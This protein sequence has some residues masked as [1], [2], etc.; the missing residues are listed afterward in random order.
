MANRWLRGKAQVPL[1][2]CP[3]ACTKGLHLLPGPGV[4]SREVKN[5]PATEE[6]VREELHRV[7]EIR[8]EKSVTVELKMVSYRWELQ[9]TVTEEK[10]IQIL[11]QRYTGFSLY[12]F[13][14][15]ENR[16]ESWHGVTAVLSVG[17]L[18]VF[19]ETKYV[20]K[21]ARKEILRHCFYDLIP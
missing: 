8:P 16:V 17:T 6:P 11:V 12:Y 15:F 3:S 14:L 5:H 21:S 9:E 1:G 10:R 2:S 13:T 20:F 7:K 4:I 18:L 19:Y